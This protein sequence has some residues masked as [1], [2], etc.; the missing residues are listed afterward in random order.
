[1][2]RGSEKGTG[3]PLHSPVSPPFPL[4]G[5]ACAITFQLES[6]KV[7][8]V[9]FHKTITIIFMAV[10]NQVPI[11]QA[12]VVFYANLLNQ[13]VNTT[14]NKHKL[15][16]LARKQVRSEDQ[17]NLLTILWDSDE[18]VHFHT[19]IFYRR[20]RSGHIDFIIPCFVSQDKTTCATTAVQPCSAAQHK[21]MLDLWPFIPPIHHSFLKYLKSPAG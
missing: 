9:T 13:N 14:H 12:S 15:F 3:Y 19:K 10:R 11:N 1:M 5:S 6:T 8:G 21:D 20:N 4:R 17:I 2:F 16:P 18:E 7:H